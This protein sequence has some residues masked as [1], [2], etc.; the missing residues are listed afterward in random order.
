MESLRNELELADRGAQNSSEDE[1]DEVEAEAEAEAEA[2]DELETLPHLEPVSWESLGTLEPMNVAT[3][4][5]SGSGANRSAAL[6]ATAFDGVRSL[7]GW[8]NSPQGDNRSYKDSRASSLGSSKAI[9]SASPSSSG[10]AVLTAVMLMLLLAVAAL[11]LGVE[12]D[13][14]GV[15]TQAWVV[16]GSWLHGQ[17][18]LR[19]LV[20]IA[21]ARAR[22]SGALQPL[23]LASNGLEEVHDDPTGVYFLVNHM[24]KSP[25]PALSSKKKSPSSTFPQ[26]SAG[27][28]LNSGPGTSSAG[29]SHDAW[30]DP[31]QD[32]LSLTARERDLEV[33]G[34][35]RG[36]ACVLRPQR[37]SSSSSG[38]SRLGIGS[39]SESVEGRLGL[40][41]SEE[42]EEA[43]AV[44]AF[45]GWSVV[46][47][48]FA[49]LQ[50]HVL[51]VSEHALSSY[52]MHRHELAI[53][54]RKLLP[55]YLLPTINKYFVCI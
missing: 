16:A 31:S 24:A 46:L 13:S 29:R 40:G 20:S 45:Q 3:A 42:E 35:T 33:C 7:I 36:D 8:W 17:S 2:G 9:R 21:S 25:L 12:V 52:F 44:E 27:S 54:S 37:Y 4:A 14:L 53:C 10:R 23:P 30:F 28:T 6:S 26:S 47:N 50:D 48:K 39:S 18:R 43:E 22:R 19:R 41:S 11:G 49:G 55:L 15:L 38:S 32:P 1:V 34:P 51:L 5:S